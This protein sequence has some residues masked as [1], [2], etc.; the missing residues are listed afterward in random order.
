MALV[1]FG[2]STCPLCGVILRPEDDLIATSHFIEFESDP[3]WRYSDAAMHRRC[4]LTWELRPQ[5]V[6]RYNQTVGTITWSNGTHHH[7]TDDVT[8]QSL[9]RNER[10]A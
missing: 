5:F 10:N 1:D 7:M 9:P 2:H 4:F 3:L 8:I 6:A